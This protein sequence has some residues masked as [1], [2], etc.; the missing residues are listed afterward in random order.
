MPPIDPVLADARVLVVEDDEAYRAVIVRQLQRGGLTDIETAANGVEGLAKVVSFRPDLVLLDVRMP[1]MDGYEMCRR[2]RADPRTADL[3]VLFQTSVSSQKE[4]VACFEAGGSD[5]IA[6][7]I[8]RRE[9][10][11][12]MAVHLQN[13]R[14]VGRLRSYASRVEREL[15]AARAMQADLSPS[16][17]RIAALAAAAGL[18]IAVHVEPSSEL[19]GDTWSILDLGAGRVGLLLADFSGHGV[20]AAINAFRL[21]TLLLRLPP[22]PDAP[23]AWLGELN[24][25]LC[26][27]LAEGQF[28]A[29]FFGVL[30]RGSDRLRYAACGGPNPALVDRAGARPLDGSGM[31]VGI[32][33]DATYD[34]REATLSRDG[35]LLLYSDALSESRGSGAPP[36]GEAGVLA[37]CEAAADRAPPLDHVLADGLAARRPL[38]DDL[39]LLW[40]TRRG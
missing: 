1:E 17:A 25:A 4:Q 35:A 20:A 5:Y 40:V 13:R 2:L 10:L 29:L 3:P 18:E 32:L 27:M 39:T 8:R 26:G 24:R 12:R 30:E 28:A 37:L 38:K 9:C 16:P 36:L 31:M 33:E 21:Q 11:A 23:G 7:P 6:K 15:S 22:D 34:T 19:G 14:M